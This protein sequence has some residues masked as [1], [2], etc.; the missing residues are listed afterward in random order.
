M[1]TPPPT[2][3]IDRAAEAQISSTVT[4]LLS[5]SATVG[6]AKIPL[7]NVVAAGLSHQAAM[8]TKVAQKVAE[9]MDPGEEKDAFV[10][11][12]DEHTTLVKMPFSHPKI[13]GHPSLHTTVS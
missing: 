7:N 4:T 13:T 9:N 12:L 1:A 10:H 2:L 11:L 5:A 6:R 8:M 3:S